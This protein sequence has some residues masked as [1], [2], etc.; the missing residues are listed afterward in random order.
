MY[1]DIAAWFYKGLCGIN[2]DPSAPGFKH[3]FIKPHVVGDLTWARGEYDSVH[4]KI[5]SDWNLAGNQF[6]LKLTIP[7]NTT[8]TVS[9]PIADAEQ[10]L[11]NGKPAGRATGV[12]FV[13]ADGRRAVFE[14]ASGTYR[15]NGL[16]AR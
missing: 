11:E 4:G 7:A 2:P 8:V 6:Q 13:R 3:F 1:G 9:L 16:L 10:V 15:F 5:V 12:R 14:V